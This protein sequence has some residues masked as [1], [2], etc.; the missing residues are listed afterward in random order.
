MIGNGDA[1]FSYD[2]T[3]HAVVFMHLCTTTDFSTMNSCYIL[4]LLAT[5]TA[6]AH[7]AGEYSI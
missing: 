1:D 2:P 4:E 7:Y 6:N 5:Y 3:K